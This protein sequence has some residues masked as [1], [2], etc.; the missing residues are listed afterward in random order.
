MDNGSGSSLVVCNLYPFA[1][2]VSEPGVALGEAVEQIDIG[3]VTLLRA[4]AKNFERVTVLCDTCDYH[5][6]SLPPSSLPHFLFL[7]AALP[8]LNRG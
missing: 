6:F 5:Q 1:K 4:A 3:G 8:G 2:T 7:L